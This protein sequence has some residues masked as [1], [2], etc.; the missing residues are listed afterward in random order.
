MGS[1]MC[2]RDRCGAWKPRRIVTLIVVLYKYTYLLTYLVACA[3]SRRSAAG[4]WTMTRW[5]TVTCCSRSV[6]RRPASAASTPT[7]IK[8]RAQQHCLE[9][10]LRKTRL[11]SLH[12]RRMNWL[13]VLSTRIGNFQLQ[14][15]QNKWINITTVF[16]PWPTPPRPIPRPPRSGLEVPRIDQDTKTTTLLDT[17][18][19]GHGHCQPPS[20]RRRPSGA[21]W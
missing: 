14:T 16:R 19:H 9:L 10:A 1:E 6:R 21:P 5:M 13:L 17:P 20:V 11:G 2:I 12:V 8:T 4:I 18:S 3:V 15:R 7:P